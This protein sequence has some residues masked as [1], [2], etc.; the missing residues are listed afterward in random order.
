MS[1]KL[2]MTIAVA[3]LPVTGMA[4]DPPAR[5]F[6]KPLLC[7]LDESD[8]GCDMTFHVRWQ[9]VVA[10][11]YCLNDDLQ[12]TPLRC[13]SLVRQGELREQRIVSEDFTYWLGDPARTSRLAA[14]KVEVL[15]VGS[16]DRRRERRTRHVWDVL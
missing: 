16:T 5:L 1:R 8:A 7:V 15:R 2:A 4:A 14:V 11:D 10:G 13:W 12:L 9:S 6:V 3:L